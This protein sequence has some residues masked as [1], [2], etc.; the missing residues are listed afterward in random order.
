MSIMHTLPNPNAIDRADDTATYDARDLIR[1]GIKAD[2][3]LD[4]QTYTLRITRAG[5]LILTK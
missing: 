2:I 1:N 3:V 4:G 5:K